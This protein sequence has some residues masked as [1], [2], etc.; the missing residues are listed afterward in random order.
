MKTDKTGFT[1]LELM[2]VVAILSILAVVAVPSFIKYMRRAKTAE[3]IDHLEKMHAGSVTYYARGQVLGGSGAAT[4]CQFPS[5]V[6]I[7]PDVTAAK[8]CDGPNDADGDSRCDVNLVPWAHSTWNALSFEMRDQHY[9]GYSYTSAGTL[10]DAT[11]VARANGDLNCDGE[12]STFERYGFGNPSATSF[13]CSAR[14]GVA[15]YVLNETE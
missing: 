8:C 7:T 6:D 13:E 3:A 15:L 11:F 10:Q 2:V 12:L 9:F 4:A 5:S 14:T 1:L